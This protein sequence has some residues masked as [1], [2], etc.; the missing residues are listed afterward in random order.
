[1]QRRNAKSRMSKS[2]VVKIIRASY[3]TV[4]GFT[5]KN[6]WWEIRDKVFKRD[7]GKCVPCARAGK[8]IPGTD[9]HHIRSLAKGGT[10]TMANLITLCGTCHE[11]RHPEN[12][13]L[14]AY[15]NR[16]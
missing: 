15:H 6:S 7:N 11:K 9:V 13:S 8:S 1:M 2:G 10:T 4:Q 14:K 16:S 3:S 5:K 12:K